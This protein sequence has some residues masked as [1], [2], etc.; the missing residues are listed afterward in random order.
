MAPPVD[1]F[2]ILK[3]KERREL[4]APKGKKRR[5]RR[6]HKSPRPLLGAQGGLF[7]MPPRPFNRTPKQS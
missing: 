7:M 2:D 5:K 6:R 4:Q 1:V 3:K